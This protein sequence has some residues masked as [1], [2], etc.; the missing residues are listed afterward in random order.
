MREQPPALILIIALIIT[1]P[2]TLILIYTYICSVHHD[3]NYR[4]VV[5]YNSNYCDIFSYNTNDYDTACCY[6]IYYDTVKYQIRLCDRF[7]KCVFKS[8][9][10]MVM[11][12]YNIPLSEFS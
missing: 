11:A 8:L 6:T 4:D 9:C 3:A 1:I 7:H 12:M 10:L 2:L 5:S